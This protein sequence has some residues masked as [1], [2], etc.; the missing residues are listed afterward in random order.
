MYRDHSMGQTPHPKPSMVSSPGTEG[1]DKSFQC[2]SPPAEGC[3]RI[4]GMV[5]LPSLVPRAVVSHSR[6][7]HTDDGCQLVGLGSAYR[8]TMRPGTLVHGGPQPGEHQ[9][10]RAKG[11]LSGTP[12]LHPS[13]TEQAC[14]SLDGQCRDQGLP[15]PPGGYQVT[16]PHA[17]GFSPLHLGREESAIVISRAYRRS[18]QHSGRLAEQ[19]HARPDG[20]EAG[21]ATIPDDH[22]ALRH[23]SGGHVRNAQQC[24]TPQILYPLPLARS[25]GGRCLNFQLATRSPLC[26]PADKDSAKS[27]RQDFA[28]E[29]RSDSGG[30]VLASQ[31]MVFGPSV[32][33]SLPAMEDSGHE[34]IPQPRISPTP[35]S[36]VVPVDRLEIERGRLREH[37]L[38]DDII[39]TMQAAR[40]PSTSRIYQATWS[41]FC[42]F[43]QENNMDL[44]SASVLQ[45]RSGLGVSP[46]SISRW[47]R[48]C[49]AEAYGTTPHILPQGITAHST[50]SAATSAAWRTQA[51]AEDICRAATWTAPSTFIRHYKLDM[52]ASAEASF[53][54]R[55]LQRVCSST[56]D[57]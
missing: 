13:S 51:S 6:P 45:T 20:M 41:A 9:S 18:G 1:Q 42:K 16:T 43:C 34:N 22:G 19:N 48:E 55:V 26:L 30:P 38:P 2:A 7:T 47:I 53:G 54:R 50:R 21:L 15:Q 17:G 14:I 46:R 11:S 25:G 36:P 56:V 8:S 5:G 40:R 10:V 29:G 24:A 3:E 35:R 28:G 49:I 27:S 39:S 4:P 52:Y 31:T 32:P 12:T 33:L 57:P 44:A 23:A 37:N